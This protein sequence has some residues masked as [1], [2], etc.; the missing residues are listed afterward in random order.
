MALGGREAY[1]RALGR[2]LGKSRD[3]AFDKAREKTRKI[4]RDK[5]RSKSLAA[6]AAQDTFSRR[7]MPKKS[8]KPKPRVPEPGILA[9]IEEEFDPAPSR[10]SLRRRPP[11][12][13]APL[14]A[15]LAAVILGFLMMTHL[16]MRHNQL[17][18]E[19]SRLNSQKVALTDLNR[20]LR[21]DMDMLTVLGDLEVVARDRV[22]L[23]SPS[24]GQIEIIE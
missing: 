8:A 9:D 5:D 23:V 10:R 20:R 7:G 17:G 19:V 21:A 1:D 2:S 13:F 3:K 6:Q 18:R 15:S 22:G 16:A 4:I 24:I 14:A 12:I 11:G